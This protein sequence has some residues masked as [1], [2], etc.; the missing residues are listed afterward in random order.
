VE[1]RAVNPWKWQ[2]Q[3][4]FEQAVE[5]TRG[6]RVLYC[7][8]QTSTDADGN[9]VPGDMAAQI[10]KALDNLEEVLAL[11][12]MTLGNVVRLNY[13]VTSIDEFFEAGMTLGARLAMADCHAAGTLLEVSR[14]AFPEYRVEVEA[15]AVA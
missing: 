12:G 6:D 14:L 9:P 10:A 11:A 3:F 8:G 4:G 2:E 1:R 5:V 13:Y 15:T 7:A